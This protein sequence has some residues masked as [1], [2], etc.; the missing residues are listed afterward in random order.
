VRQVAVKSGINET[1][2][3]AG[4]KVEIG[5]VKL[6]ALWPPAVLD[7]RSNAGSLVIRLMCGGVRILLT[8]DIESESERSLLSLGSDLDADI[9]Q[10]AHHGSA[11]SSTMD[12]LTRVKPK[13]ALA[14]TGLRPRYSYPNATVIDRVRRIPAVLVDQKS[15]I[16]T[17]WWESPDRMTIESEPRVYVPLHKRTLGD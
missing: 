13:I 2:L 6:T 9:L 7:E 8:G 16:D 3:E 1:Q 11:T 5:N 10:L 17:I 4:Q 14:A 15:E 12:F